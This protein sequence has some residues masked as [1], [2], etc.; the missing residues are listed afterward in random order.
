M[1]EE[2]T[3]PSILDQL[4]LQKNLGYEVLTR[5]L[6]K[7]FRSSQESKLKPELAHVNKFIIQESANVMKRNVLQMTF[8]GN[9]HILAQNLPYMPFRAFQVA[10]SI[11]T[12]CTT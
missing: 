7:Y 1:D 4:M 11:N 6:A 9:L 10:N 12:L 5:I 8:L 3:K 2:V